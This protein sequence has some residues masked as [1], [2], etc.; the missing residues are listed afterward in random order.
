MKTESTLTRPK[1]LKEVAEQSESIEDFG[2]NL[3]DWQHEI[4]HAGVHSRKDLA[5]R[6][7]EEP[8]LL[9]QRFAQG[10]V[11]DAYLAAYAEWIAENARTPPPNWTQKRNRCAHEPWFSSPD[12]TYLLAH[13][14]ASFRKRNLFT[15]PESVFSP[16][17]GR[18]RVPAEQLR[19]KA[20]LRQHAYRVRIR[21]LV[22][23]ARKAR[24]S[25][26]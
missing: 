8:P 20:V 14:P 10:D 9:I 4:R 18:P 23:E 25:P 1:T 3:R 19:R 5:A 21:E 16:R 13:S 7:E 22:A 2:L 6:L 24:R 11:A 15:V 17:R 12:R 26:N